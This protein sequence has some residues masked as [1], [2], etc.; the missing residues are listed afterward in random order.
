MS[1]APTK[2]R[3]TGAAEPTW[4]I[5]QLFPTQGNW[6]E[7]EYLALHTNH[8]VE[9]SHGVLEVLPMPTT[10]HQFLV[11][12]LYRL[13]SAFATP[14]DLGTVLV[15]PLRVRLWR[16]KFRE[17]DIVFLLK[18]HTDRIGEE[19]WSGADVVME[20]VS[21][22]EEDRRRDLII[23]RAEYARAGI[24]EYWI[25]D[26]REERI[27]VLRLAGKRYVV[28]GEFMKGSIA[29]SHLLDGFTVNV[30]DAF[31]QRVGTTVPTKSSGKPRRRV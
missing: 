3:A 10:S 27:T 5:A 20:V 24:R 31:S 6:S 7:E 15:A 19:F 12:Y 2:S 21:G 28:H 13:V 22:E 16:G 25:V 29:T 23:K 9:F 11:T 14:A 18:E 8:L 4:Q 1:Q 26:P 30:S 17:P